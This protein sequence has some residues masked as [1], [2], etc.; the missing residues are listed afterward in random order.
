[1]T[2]MAGM[3][4]A[5]LVNK[6]LDSVLSSLI[7]H[8]HEFIHHEILLFAFYIMHRALLLTESRQ[9]FKGAPLALGKDALQR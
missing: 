5:P 8:A 1:M 6:R 2:G 3:A 9:A 4:Q 7:N